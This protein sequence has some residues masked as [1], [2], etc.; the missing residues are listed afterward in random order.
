MDSEWKSRFRLDCG[1]CNECIGRLSGQNGGREVKFE[2]ML[3]PVDA[4]G[5]T[6]EQARALPFEFGVSRVVKPDFVHDRVWM[7]ACMTLTCG[8]LG[9]SDSVIGMLPIRRNDISGV[10]DLSDLARIVAACPTAVVE[11]LSA[12][13]YYAEHFV[14][15][16]NRSLPG[17]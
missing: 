5:M 11:A 7:G 13:P 1:A 14:N 6:D 2:L 15:V 4:D 9:E 12:C 17:P 8:S 16:S 3:H 10:G